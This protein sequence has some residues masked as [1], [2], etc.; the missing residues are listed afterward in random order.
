MV[1]PDRFRLLQGE[2]ALATYEFGTG[3]ALHH[4]CRYCGVA[5]F[6][7]PRANP[8]NYMLNAR[9][10]EGVELD[11]FLER[12]RFD[13]L[14]CEGRPDAP[15]TGIWNVSAVLPTRLPSNQRL[16][17]TGRRTAGDRLGVRV[18]GRSTADR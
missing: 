3:R 11:S 5:S 14:S 10:I 18:A 8:S 13:G 12:V 16:E 9:C 1:S 2:D 6:Y 4:F 7:R 17:Q 15:Y